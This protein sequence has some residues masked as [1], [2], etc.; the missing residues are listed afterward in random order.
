MSDVSHLFPNLARAL[1][2][3]DNGPEGDG[4]EDPSH[5]GVTDDQIETYLQQMGS[6]RAPLQ[7][8]ISGQQVPQTPEFANNGRAVPPG[9][10]YME[11]PQAPDSAAASGDG[12]AAAVEEEVPEPAAPPPPPPPSPAAAVPPTPDHYDIAGRR[13]DRA[14]AEAWAQFDA[15]VTADPQLRAVIENYLKARGQPQPPQT[16]Q[17]PQP[18]EL[19]TLSQLPPEYQ[20]DETITSLYNTVRAQQDAI[21]R[22][23]RQAAQAEQYASHNI[24][25]TYADIAQGAITEFQKSRQLD[26]PT[27][28]AVSRAARASGFAEKYMS[29]VDPLTGTTVAPD[30]FK[31]VMSALEAG[32]L[33]APET[34]DL[35][36]QRQIDARVRRAQDEV[37]RK[38]KLAGVSGASGSVP[39]TQTI[40]DNPQDARAAMTEEISQMLN[41]SWTGDGS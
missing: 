1:E 12:Q 19:P 41:G 37:S 9:E 33:M 3:W 8:A 16:P 27:M 28:T 35:E 17:T 10:S 7:P 15:M 24:Q 5:A 18:P 34:R 20:N 29:G 39:R 40:P 32:Y 13:Y 11:P 21:D 2:N 36:V 22:I 14:Q 6:L 30:P 26:D 23:S 4:H 38:E 25:R 31:A